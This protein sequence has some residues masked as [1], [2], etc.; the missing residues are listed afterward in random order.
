MLSV[1][2]TIFDCLSHFLM[3]QK[4][5]ICIYDLY[6]N[7]YVIIY[8]IYLRNPYLSFLLILGGVVPIS[9]PIISEA[10]AILTSQTSILKT[11][12]DIH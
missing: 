4:I 11:V 9:H 12:F 6:V 2:L 1:G 5:N 10:A 7:I 8:K 3:S